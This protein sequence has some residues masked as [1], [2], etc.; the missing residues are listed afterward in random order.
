MHGF[1]MDNQNH[2]FKWENII[3]KAAL[4]IAQMPKESFQF[5][6]DWAIFMFWEYLS[7]T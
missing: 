7:I 3:L 2:V 4:K 1:C 6:A 5:G